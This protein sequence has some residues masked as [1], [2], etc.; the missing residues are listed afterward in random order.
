MNYNELHTIA[1]SKNQT[2]FSR[3]ITWTCKSFRTCPQHV[4][5]AN[6]KNFANNIENN[7]AWTNEFQFQA[8]KP[9]MLPSI[10]TGVLEFVVYLYTRTIIS[11]W[12]KKTFVCGDMTKTMTRIKTGCCC[13]IQSK[14]QTSSPCWFHLASE[15]QRQWNCHALHQTLSAR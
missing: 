5:D 15:F 1:V 8:L 6:G 11:C 9:V 12:R 2:L 4:L 14:V 13:W 3:V 10:F 7:R